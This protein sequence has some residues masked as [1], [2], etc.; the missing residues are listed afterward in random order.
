MWRGGGAGGAVAG[1]AAAAAGVAG[2]AK[3]G[4]EG[5]LGVGGRSVVVVA[6]DDGVGG[7]T[8]DGGGNGHVLSGLHFDGCCWFGLIC[9]RWYEFGMLVFNGLRKVFVVIESIVVLQ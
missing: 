6:D 2:F 3:A 7:V 8:A 4:E 5:C 1:T 9:V